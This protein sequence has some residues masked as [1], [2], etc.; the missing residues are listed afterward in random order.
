MGI[1]CENYCELRVKAEWLSESGSVV[2]SDTF[3]VEILGGRVNVIPL[4][5][6]TRDSKSVRIQEILDLT[7]FKTIYRN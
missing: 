3:R 2:Y 7:L 1:W 5:S 4:Y 6:P